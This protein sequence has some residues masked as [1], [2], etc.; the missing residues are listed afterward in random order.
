MTGKGHIGPSNFQCNLKLK[1][2]VAFDNEVTWTLGRRCGWQDFALRPGQGRTRCWCFRTNFN[3]KTHWQD[4]IFINLCSSQH[5]SLVNIWKHSKKHLQQNSPQSLTDSCA[6][7]GKTASKTGDQISCLHNSSTLGPFFK[8]SEDTVPIWYFCC[9]TW[10]Q[11][12]KRTR[13]PAT[14]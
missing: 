8:N 12:T 1:Q 2:E 3:W 6:Y 13:D 11:T 14:I 7:G 5:A 10:T 4:T 9:R